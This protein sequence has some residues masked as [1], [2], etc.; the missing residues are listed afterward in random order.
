M[1]DE[2]NIPSIDHRLQLG[3]LLA[4]T[5]SELIEAKQTFDARTALSELRDPEIADVL[6]AL[7][8]AHRA[9]A[10]RLL[11]RARAAE[12]FTH[13]PP[14]QQEALLDE[15]T[16]EQL[17]QIFNEMNPDDRAE[18]FEELP[19]QLV[20]KLL[21]LMKP[22]ERRMT[23]V[24]LGYPEQSVG[25]LMTPE[26]LT[27]RAEWTVE[28]ALEHIRRRGRD[29]ETL[30]TLY[31]VDEH[32]RLFAY[33][34]LRAVLLAEPTQTCGDLAQSDVIYLGATDDREEAVRMMA[35]YDLPV[36][37]VVDRDGVLVGVVTYDDVADV[38]EEEVTE[39]IQKLGGMEALDAPY[40]SSPLLELVKKRGVWLVVLFA[41]GLLTIVAMAGFR[42]E[43]DQ[44]V[45]L[46]LFVPLIIASG[47]NSGS[48]AASIMI[49]AIAIGEVN[50]RDWRRVAVRELLSGLMMGAGL[51]MLGLVV[52]LAAD[53]LGWLS[54]MEGG[55]SPTMLAMTVAGS[56]LGVILCGT[57]VGSL[58]PFALRAFGFDPA[59]G[60]T[61]LVATIVDVSGLVI[62][63]MLAKVLLGL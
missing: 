23:Q 58:L 46:S 40:L 36:L 7:P 19:G 28:R 21:A 42:T 17:A 29:A 61:P 18:V 63:F 20:T 25:R 52:V 31:M 15:M 16:H 35:R 60:S 59:A 1:A 41:G 5:I 62:Y 10:F 50:G 3:E 38:A 26:Y 37:P 54:S 9:V 44:V 24:I 6:T 8:L 56:I 53:A 57:L 51:A 27:C 4:P 12:V 39:D 30:N 47:G 43:I 13:L 33:V 2:Q 34:A 14:D 49:R 22:S 11:P 32:G 48:Q 45:A 55:H